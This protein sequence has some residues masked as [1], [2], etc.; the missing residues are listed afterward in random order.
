MVELNA[1]LSSLGV[2]LAGWTLTGGYGISA[3]GRTIAGTGTHGGVEQEAWVATISGDI[4]RTGACCRGATCVA[5][6]A[7]DCIG[8]AGAFAG[9]DVACN[10]L[11]DDAAPCCRANFNHSGGLSV[12]DIFAF[13]N[14]WFAGDSSTDF[15]SSCSLSVQDI[16]DFLAAWFVG[17]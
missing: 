8:T 1:Y 11:G 12:Q 9:P 13:L 3:D 10:V 5:T 15:N 7:A 17:C 14:A 4:V 16:F 6:T 2:N